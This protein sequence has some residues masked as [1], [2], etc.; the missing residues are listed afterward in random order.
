MH[1]SQQEGTEATCLPLTH[2]KKAAGRLLHGIK[3][4]LF[5]LKFEHSFYSNLNTMGFI[6]DGLMGPVN[7]RSV[8]LWNRSSSLP[9]VFPPDED[10]P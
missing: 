5:C 3:L 9:I 8:T 1:S 7:V 2:K 10:L 6:F 4:W